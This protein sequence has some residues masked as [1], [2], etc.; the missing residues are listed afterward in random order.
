MLALKE[1]VLPAFVH[2]TF[3]PRKALANL[4][5][6]DGKEHLESALSSEIRK[7]IG[8]CILSPASVVLMRVFSSASIVPSSKQSPR[9]LAGSFP[10]CFWVRFRR[11]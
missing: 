4:D 11:L 8:P 5:Q 2:P 6:A 9:Q 10:S 3:G 1:S 7:M